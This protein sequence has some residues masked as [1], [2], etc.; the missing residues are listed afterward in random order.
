MTTK[1][2]EHTILCTLSIYEHCI[3]IRN[4][5][6]NPIPYSRISVIFYFYCQSQ[7]YVLNSALSYQ[8]CCISVVGYP[9]FINHASTR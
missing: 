6:K 9:V 8:P 1:W 2:V 4:S 7:I 3:P 5:D